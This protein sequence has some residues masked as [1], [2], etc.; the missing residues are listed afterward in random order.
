MGHASPRAALIYQ[1]ATV[2]REAAIA[3]GISRLV[4]QTAN[5]GQGQ[6]FPTGPGGRQLA[7]SLHWSDP[8]GTA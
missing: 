3:E 6:G 5:A 1:H 8:A 2:E 4:E 7:E